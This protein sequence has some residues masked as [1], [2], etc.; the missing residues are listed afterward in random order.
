MSGIIEK[1]TL[2]D[3][4]GYA[5]PGSMFLG[6]AVFTFLAANG[7]LKDVYDTYKGGAGY[8]FTVLLV[9]GYAAG[10]LISEITDIIAGFFRE[11]LD[12]ELKQELKK[13]KINER[14]AEHV[15]K[16]AGYMKPEDRIS[17]LDQ[18]LP[19]IAS[20]YGVIQTDAKYSRLHNYASARLICKNMAF[21]CFSGTGMVMALILK[22]SNQ[23][24]DL[25]IVQ[26]A[27]ELAIPC[28]MCLLFIRRW[29]RMFIK[30]QLYTVVWFL[31]KNISS[32]S[33]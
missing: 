27:A 13:K 33:S 19:Y 26:M 20:M 8:F 14:Q 5:L 2:Y 11:S 3:L 10:M 12:Y 32:G 24:A 21:V 1:I 23:A 17:S 31:E 7:D 29:K 15:L 30:T 9:L 4:L 18:L 25:R 22:V 6:M 16:K 28:V